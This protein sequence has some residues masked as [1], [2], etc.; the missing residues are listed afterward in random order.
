M[1]II[2]KEKGY[3]SRKEYRLKNFDYSNPGSY[4]VTVCTKE[5]KNYF[6]KRVGASIGRPSDIVL[7]DY[8]MLVDEA[9]KIFFG[10]R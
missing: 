1:R 4:F 5:R 3:R 10:Y 6:W 7:S 2:D 8:G 9:I